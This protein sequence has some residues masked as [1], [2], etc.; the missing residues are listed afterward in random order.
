MRISDFGFR[1]SECLVRF[2]V[3]QSE[4]PNPKCLAWVV[5]VFA[6]LLLPSLAGACPGCKEALFDPGQITQRVATAQGYALS[7]GLLLGMPALLLTGIASLIVRSR[8]KSQ[9]RI[10]TLRLSR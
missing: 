1:I 4:I 9:T 5:G 10:D 6:L 8:R 3:P 7:I 2:F